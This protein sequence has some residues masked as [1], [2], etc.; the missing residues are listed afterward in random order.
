MDE[1]RKIAENSDMIVNGYAFKKLE[2]TF[3]RVVN[4]NRLDHCAVFNQENQIIETSMDDIEA[5]IASEYLS[6][7]RMQLEDE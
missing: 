5:A 7:N 1:I 6:R 4:L 3:I 2:N